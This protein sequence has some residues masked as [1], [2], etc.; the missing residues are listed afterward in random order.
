MKFSLDLR[1]KILRALLLSASLL[2]LSGCL[3]TGPER[4]SPEELELERKL[5]QAQAKEDN[6][7]MDGRRMEVIGQAL[8]LIGIPYRLGG[9]D[10]D[11]GF[12]CS[13]L[14]QYSLNN[15][16]V[17]TPRTAAEQ[18]TQAQPK[19][20]DDLLPGDLIFFRIDRSINHVGIYLGGGDFIHAPRAGSPVR[21]ESL[22]KSYWRKRFEGV[23]SYL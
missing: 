6:S 12:D 16:G 7:Q 22:H 9:T 10:P 15:V 2:A 20:V 23:G 8:S 3:S 21:L 17:Q 19:P 14:V 5:T 1:K 13:G 18:F 4:P 11:K